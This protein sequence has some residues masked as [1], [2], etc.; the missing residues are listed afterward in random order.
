MNY[1]LSQLH[2]IIATLSRPLKQ[3][4]DIHGPF[5]QGALREM[6]EDILYHISIYLLYAP[7]SKREI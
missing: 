1:H 3:I 6:L 5:G 7:R 4:I 2:L